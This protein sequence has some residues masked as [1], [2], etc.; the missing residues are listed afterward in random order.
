MLNPI[1][2]LS[3]TM[4]IVFVIMVMGIFSFCM[5]HYAT[6]QMNLIQV[7]YD[8]LLNTTAQS[9]T[10]AAI[11]VGEVRGV[12]HQAYRIIASDDAGQ[13]NDAITTTN[14]NLT[15]Y[16]ESVEQ[17]KKQNPEWGK[18][19]DIIESDK[20]ELSSL[21]EKIIEL[22]KS[23]K[24]AEAMH[25]VASQFDPL[26]NKIHDE[27][28]G[29]RKEA[30]AT[31]DNQSDIAANNAK[32]IVQLITNINIAGILILAL[33]A[34]Y[35]TNI[36]VS[37]P[38]RRVTTVLSQ[39]ANGE[40]NMDI[41]QSRQTDEVGKLTNAAFALRKTVADAFR[42][43]QMVED[44]PI[45]IMYADPKDDFKITY[46]NKTSKE[47]LKAVEQYLPITVDKI[48]GSSFDVFHKNPHHQRKL[49][50]DPSNLP[51]RAKIQV[52]PE[53]L[54]LKVS[55]IRDKDGNYIG[56]MLTWAV[57]T[58]QVKLADEFESTIGAVIKSVLTSSGMMQNSA[59]TL[60]AASEKTNTQVTTVA[61]AAE[62]ASTNVQAVAAATEELSNSIAEIGKQVHDSSRITA[63]AV[64][65][66]ETTNEVVAKLSNAAIK[67]DSV[68]QLINN[69]AN[70]TNLLALNA[71]IEAARAGEAGKGFAVV[72]AEVKNLANQTAK[73]TEEITE[74]IVDI[75]NSSEAAVESIRSIGET[76]GQINQIASAIAAAVEQQ[77]AAT[78]EISRNVQQASTGTSDV[79]NTISGVSQTASDTGQMALQVLQAANDL[80][81]QGQILKKEAD[82]FIGRV[83]IA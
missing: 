36:T 12:G 66:A 22:K 7:E 19:L 65:Q 33:L 53:V 55:A 5:N 69:I 78:V 24:S 28:V 13:I 77:S 8:A 59:S 26:L 57:V 52:G 16:K 27:L 23:G 64:K 45:N 50:A 51:H 4:K 48:L 72:A 35:I 30:E 58:A 60:T 80:S 29:L 82:N 61:A 2:N 73:A 83:R 41:K 46:I 39:L 9:A 3:L 38:I 70:Q 43:S 40:S 15:N 18:Q 54:D 14:K 1:S 10:D 32:E 47:T 6:N 49:L 71:T 76:I 37:K 34:G 81:Q 79:S 42:L 56:P 67:V 20:I 68:V 25:I 74:Q 21:F 31:L 44:M 63:D 11:L 17:L 62:E 75:K